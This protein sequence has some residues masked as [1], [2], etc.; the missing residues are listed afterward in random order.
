MG[1]VAYARRGYCFLL[2]LLLL[3]L[4]LVCGLRDDVIQLLGASTVRAADAV[5]FKV[6]MPGFVSQSLGMEV[7]G[8]VGREKKKTRDPSDQRPTDEQATTLC[9]Y[10]TV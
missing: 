8:M 1:D 4:L 9:N 5:G 10:S 6:P 7:M 3:L 2:L